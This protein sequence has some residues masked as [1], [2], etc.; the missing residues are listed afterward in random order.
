MRHLDELAEQVSP[1]VGKVLGQH[2]LVDGQQRQAPM[3]GLGDR[4]MKPARLADADQDE[5]WLQGDR[6]HRGGR[7]RVLDPVM[8]RSRNRDPRG[9]V[10]HD[11]A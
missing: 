8:Q 11:V 10:A 9:E 4:A 2:R 5:R 1:A 7:H 3:C 6:A